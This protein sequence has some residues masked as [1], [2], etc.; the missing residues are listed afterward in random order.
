M[1]GS[2]RAHNA[3]APNCGTAMTV[4]ADLGP[5]LP[6]SGYGGGSSLERGIATRALADLDGRVGSRL[7]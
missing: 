7:E 4:C 5:F 6:L 3:A 2:S 1:T